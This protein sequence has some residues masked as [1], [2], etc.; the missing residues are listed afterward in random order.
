MFGAHLG[1]GLRLWVAGEFLYAVGREVQLQLPAIVSFPPAGR[2][3]AQRE[4]PAEAGR[5]CTASNS[6]LSTLDFKLSIS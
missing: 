3:G 1:F 5:Q 2:S 6:R 4:S